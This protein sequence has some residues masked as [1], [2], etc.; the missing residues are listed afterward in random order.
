VKFRL[1]AWILGVA[2]LIWTFVTPL[3]RGNDGALQGSICLPIDISLAFIILGWG[4]NSRFKKFVSWFALA[5]IGQAAALQLINAGPLVHY[6]HYR[7]IDQFLVGNNLLPLVILIIQLILV[8]LGI[9]SRW[10]QIRH[11]V[12]NSFKLW[13]LLGIGLFIIFSAAAAQRNIPQYG[14]DLFISIFIQFINLANIVLVVWALPDDTLVSF[15]RSVEKLFGWLIKEKQADKSHLDR[16]AF[17]FAIWVFGLALILCNFSYQAFPHITDEV[18]YYIQA[19]FLAQGAITLPAPPVPEAF[20]I[21]MM[22]FNGDQWYSAMPPGWPAML[23]LGMRLG[24]PWIVNPLLAGI[25][26]LLAYLLFQELYNRRFAR[27]SIFLLS[28][29]PW[30]IFMGMNYMNHMFTLT[31]FLL[32]GILIVW[33]RRK[34][35]ARW[36]LL[37]GIAV[38]TVTL[39]RPLDGV[40]VGVVMGLW[41]IGIGGRRLNIASI[42][43][44]TLGVMCIGIVVLSYNYTLTNSPTTFPV[45]AYFDEHYG[46]GSNDLGFGANRGLGWP[47]QPFQGH[48]PLGGMINANLNTFSIN[49]ELFGW[50][51]GSLFLVALIIF[52]G[53]LLKSDY[54]ML[55]IC[56]AI[57]I[58]YFFYYYS[59]GPDFGARYW[60]LMLIPLIA[61]TIRGIE[62]LQKKLETAIVGSKT[63]GVKVMSGVLCLSF[64]A[65]INYFPWRA[66]DKYF[67]FWGMRPDIASLNKEYSFTNGLILIHGNVSHPDYASAAVYNPLDWN[68]S[69]PIYAWDKD[70]SIEAQLLQAFPT[71]T[72]WVVDAP[73]ITHAGYEVVE[74]PL[75]AQEIASPLNSNQINT[76]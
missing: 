12:R 35:E 6:Q 2:I 32:A 27:I 76:P 65:L 52:S 53:S 25:N 50:S 33:A 68:S 72:V 73:S 56:L 40:I 13:Q 39:I 60:F 61:L 37:A 22:E 34:G 66:T 5:L 64:M 26:I 31:C 71:R 59:G 63:I 70:P 58:P 10:L 28:C 41:V 54:L 42:A 3:F 24:I 9:R 19:K 23:S 15:T 55:A 44:F 18:V 38:G 45:N 21:Y 1:I 49:I 11:W 16:Y 74:G 62:F 46:P 48:D 51:I 47:L 7:T 43:T 67:H 57:F 20:D 17:V 8:S 36:G 4:I 30:Y 14:A 69:E 29:S 75:S